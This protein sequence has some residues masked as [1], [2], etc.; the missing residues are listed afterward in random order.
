M[1]F[2]MRAPEECASWEWELDH[3]A[4]PGLASAL[5][6]AARMSALLRNH[7]LLE[8]SQME[9]LWFAYGVGGIGIK[10]TL[11][12]MGPLDPADLAQR[13]ERSQ[14]SGYPDAQV[15]NLTVSGRGT[16]FDAEGEERHEKDLV[17]LSVDPDEY[18]L[19]ADV[20]VFHDIWG[21]FDFRGF[22]HPE[23]YKRNAPRL[24]AALGE[25]DALLGTTAVAG[26]ATYFGRA[27]GRGIEMPDVI[28]GRGPDLTDRL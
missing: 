24:A 9:W 16:W 2:L 6:T 20:A 12:V 11:P 22:P 18:Q 7:R 8:P 1:S 15:G 26:D 25:L 5:S 23:V 19:T 21:H 27:E 10:T 17:V 4:P 3:F 14:P 13:I 28:D